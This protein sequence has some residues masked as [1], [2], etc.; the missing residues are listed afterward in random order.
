MIGLT[1]HTD[2]V[3]VVKMSL[4][5]PGPQGWGAKPIHCLSGSGVPGSNSDG[6][7]CIQWR[8]QDFVKGRD[9]QGVWGPRCGAWASPPEARDNSQKI[10][11]KI[12]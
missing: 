6:P 12:A 9:I 4:K 8:S 1:D 5:A 3:Q 2:A 11:L 10:A 7:G